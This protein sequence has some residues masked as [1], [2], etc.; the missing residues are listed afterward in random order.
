MRLIDE[1]GKLFGLVNPI[2]LLVVLLI[3]LIAGGA[4]YKLKFSAAGSA[5]KTVYATVRIP[6]VIP[7]VADKVKVG[8]KIVSGTS[9]T[10]VEIVKV[11]AKPSEVVTSTAV[12]ERK[13]ATDPWNKDL[14]VTVKGK[15]GI[16]EAEVNMGGQEIRVG[17]DYF[18]K[19]FTSELKGTIIEVKID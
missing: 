13:L 2:D 5:A 1:K 8:D 11:E 10:D 6:L 16:P 4:V 18:V 14:Y 3:V 19:T 9:Y 17:K 15:T 12:G 7:Y